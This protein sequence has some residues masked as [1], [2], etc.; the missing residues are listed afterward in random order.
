MTD[1]IDITFDFRSDTPEGGDPD[2]CSPTLRAYHKLLWSKPLPNG[3]MF[4]LDD[5]TPGAY[6]HHRSDLGE[7]F[8]SS[9]TSNSS[10]KNMSHVAHIRSQIPD[11]E[12]N[13]FRT[14]LYSI[15]NMI[16]FPGRQVGGRW[17]INQARGCY[18]SIGDRF[19]LTLE[20]IRLQYSCRPN[21]LSG[22]FKRYADFFDLF[23]DFRGYVEFF[24]L[25][26]LVTADCSA[27]K[28][29]LPFIDFDRQ[30]PHPESVA[31]FRTYL[32]EATRFIQARN[33]RILKYVRGR[34]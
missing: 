27:V 30:P 25:H 16:V 1:P 24:L 29:L 33:L 32:Q 13:R 23:G 5:T 4:T 14:I 2:A 10:F 7:F 31:A 34:K 17:T 12:L 21:P 6:L 22:P 19:D 15:G 11:D 8:L 20:G 18:R 9:D 28:F 26:D 3:V